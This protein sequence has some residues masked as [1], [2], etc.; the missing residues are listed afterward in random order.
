MKLCSF[1]VLMILSSIS[2][3]FASDT[4]LKA[5]VLAEK[6]WGFYNKSGHLEGITVSYFETLAKFLGEPI[7]VVLVP[8]Q[9][10][11][12]GMEKGNYDLTVTFPEYLSERYAT[13]LEPTIRLDTMLVGLKGLEIKSTDDIQKLRLAIVRGA[14]TGT[15][16]DHNR[17]IKKVET[18]NFTEAL[19]LLK[20]GRVDAVTATESVIHA[21]LPKVGMTSDDIGTPYFLSCQQ[22]ILML[23]NASEKLTMMPKIK[24]AAKEFKNSPEWKALL[25]DAKKLAPHLSHKHNHP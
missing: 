25:L 2:F 23:S 15:W 22:A 1:L 13:P 12:W 20:K 3:C 18:A 21:S 4:S 17:S 14:S 16:I 6:P 11:I 5:V 9:R 24:K 7:D 10:L 19:W 8:R